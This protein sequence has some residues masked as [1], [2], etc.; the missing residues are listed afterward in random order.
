MSAISSKL[1]LT[2]KT[3]FTYTI[4]CDPELFVVDATGKIRSAH[5]LV[6]GSKL[7]PFR[8]SKGALQPDGTSAEFNIDPALTPE[9]FSENIKLVLRD[10]QKTIREK[11]NTLDLKIAPVAW[12]NKDY[13]ATLPAEALAFGC[14]PDFNAWENGKVTQFNGTDEPFRTGAGHV[15]VGWT[16]F[17]DP[18]DGAHQ[19][20]CI[21]AT[22]QLDAVLYPMSIAWDADKK[23]RELYGKMGAYRAKPYG[24]EYRPL[25]NAWVADPD[26]HKWVFEATKRAMELLDHATQPVR[27]WVDKDLSPKLSLLREG[28]NMFQAETKQY[29]D[30]LVDLGF[31][32]LPAFYRKSFGG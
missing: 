14:T 30:I 7:Q 15:H 5:D 24:F 29:H 23:R 21:Q 13:F 2:G 9:E 4:G 1:A 16:E 26:L 8:V 11:D 17:E 28:K 27:L 3:Q 22:K 12:F 6:P 20:D 18:A 32:P 10:L 25:S 19:Y 31:P